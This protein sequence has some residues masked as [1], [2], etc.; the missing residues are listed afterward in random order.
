MAP[1]KFLQPFTW[2]QKSKGMHTKK[3]GNLYLLLVPHFEAFALPITAK[4][5]TQKPTP[6][7]IRGISI[8]FGKGT[9]KA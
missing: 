3:R 1:E 6:I 2:R 4:R 9:L 8:P 5:A 7:C